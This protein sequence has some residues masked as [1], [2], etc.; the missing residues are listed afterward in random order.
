MSGVLLCGR[1]SEEVRRRFQEVSGVE[2]AKVGVSP[3][4]G[5]RGG[6][7]VEGGAA[8]AVGLVDA[9]PGSHQCDSALVAAVG[10]CIVQW[11]P[12]E[13]WKRRGG[14][15]RDRSKCTRRAAKSCFVT[16]SLASDSPTLT[17]SFVSLIRQS[18]RTTCTH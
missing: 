3:P 4:V 1:E 6:S 13:K 8:F 12:G 10:G 7:I 11:S 9:C 2:R 15:I 14:R 18:L 5:V 16:F 17:L